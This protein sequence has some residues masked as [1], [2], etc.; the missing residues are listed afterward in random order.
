M[1]VSI[2]YNDLG[3]RSTLSAP[4]QSNVLD[5]SDEKPVVCTSGPVLDFNLK[6]I[7]KKKKKEEKEEEER[8]NIKVETEYQNEREKT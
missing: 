4:V 1:F 8:G 5:D 3:N 2:L 6:R 7:T